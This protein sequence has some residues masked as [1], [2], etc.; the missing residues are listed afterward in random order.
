ME[1]KVN[2]LKDAIKTCLNKYGYDNSNTNI[3]KNLVYNAIEGKYKYF[4]RSNGAR[5]YVMFK[6]ANGGIINELLSSTKIKNSD[7]DFIVEE[8]IKKYFNEDEKINIKEEIKE[9]SNIEKITQKIRYL[10]ITANSEEEFFNKNWDTFIDI[11]INGSD[12][13]SSDEL[14][15]DMIYAALEEAKK[16]KNIDNIIKPIKLEDN[17]LTIMD[18]IR[19]V[20]DYINHES[21]EDLFYIINQ[22]KIFSGLL[23]QNLFNFAY[24]KKEN[25]DN[26]FKKLDKELLK[27]DEIKSKANEIYSKLNHL[28]SKISLNKEQIVLTLVKNSLLIYMFS[29]GK[30]IKEIEKIYSGIKEEDKDT[31]NNRLNTNNSIIYNL[32]SKKENTTKDDLVNSIYNLSDKILYYLAN[33]YVISRSLSDSKDKLDSALFYGTKEELEIYDLLCEKDFVSLLE[34]K[35]LEEDKILVA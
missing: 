24:L 7:I 28:D 6:Y 19:I 27:Y 33:M 1:Y 31:I 5:E 8:Y 17:N 21:I 9:N 20:N 11:F 2:S 15:Y 13:I 14:R 25:N 35:E 16:Y 32:F 18:S 10:D 23:L 22:N 30:N 12:S 3:I 4:T 29:K 34:D 26:L